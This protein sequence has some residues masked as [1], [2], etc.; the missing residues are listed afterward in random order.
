MSIFNTKPGMTRIVAFSLAFILYFM[1]AA[2][3]ANGQSAGQKPS[4]FPLWNFD[5]VNHSC[6]AKGRLQDK[7]YCESKM[8]DQIIAQ[9]KSAI[10]ILISQLT[11]T[12]ATKE[13]IYD[14]W[15]KTRAGDIAY[16][17][18]TDLFTDANWTTFTM[19]GL[20]ALKENCS[21]NIAA[22]PCWREFLK[23]HGRKFVQDQWLAAWNANKDRVF[24]DEKE[25]CFRFSAKVEK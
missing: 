23:K 4:K 2:V 8:M 6:R 16:F 19:P 10:P 15:Y 7:D 11:D 17:I 14:Y 21:E 5:E 25:R 22:E 12:R 3:P 9:G 13:P 18:L 20:E 1:I 24:W